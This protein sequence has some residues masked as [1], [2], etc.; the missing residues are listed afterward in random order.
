MQTFDD[1][2]ILKYPAL[3]SVSLE[4]LTDSQLETIAPDT[5]VFASM[6]R[7]Y[8]VIIRRRS[9]KEIYEI[10]TL[11]VDPRIALI[12]AASR[13]KLGVQLFPNIDTVKALMFGPTDVS[14]TFEDTS[15]NIFVEGIKRVSAALTASILIGQLSQL[16]EQSQH[17]V[18]LERQALDDLDR[19]IKVPDLEVALKDSTR[20]SNEVDDYAFYFEKKDISLGSSTIRAELF[21]P[22]SLSTGWN[23]VGNYT[24]NFTSSQIVADLA[25]AINTVTL[26]NKSSNIIAAPV[27]SAGPNLHKIDFLARE[28][29]VA[30]TAEVISLKLTYLGNTK[31]EIPFKWGISVANLEPT[32]INSLILSVQQGRAGAVSGSSGSNTSAKSQPVVLYFRRRTISTLEEVIDY[33]G[34]SIPKSIWTN[35]KLIFR[36]SPNQASSVE[37]E[38]PYL[39][40]TATQLTLDKDRPSQ[41]AEALLNGMYAVKGATRALGSLFRNDDVTNLTSSYSALE[42]IAF[43][44]TNPETWII[45]DVLEIPLDIEMAVGDLV[46]PL[47]PFS[48]KSRSIRVE[49]V[50]RNNS[51][52]NIIDSSFTA[53]SAPRSVQ[54]GSS[55]FIREALEKGHRWSNY[56]Q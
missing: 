23:L 51:S 1:R 40:N 37:I 46:A 20:A 33:D 45:L 48:N 47:T 29:D 7:G 11:Q 2:F 50:Y 27:L 42:L 3:A 39:V 32:T 22:S 10:A 55:S 14:T 26:V 53:K 16:P 4:Q 17:A 5:K 13:D 12:L 34:N 21:M 41:V 6:V 19:I 24:G 44:V 43:S 28:R 18:I 35:G 54:I 25:D 49:S 52:V 56:E 30:I 8:S 38:I 15:L 31:K 36:I 9:T